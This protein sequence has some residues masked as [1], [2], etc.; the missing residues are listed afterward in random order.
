MFTYA[1]LSFSDTLSNWLEDASSSDDHGLES[2]MEI[3]N[4]S[5]IQLSDRVYNVT[6]PAYDVYSLRLRLRI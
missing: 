3:R 1:S 6:F 4:I 2:L 5:V